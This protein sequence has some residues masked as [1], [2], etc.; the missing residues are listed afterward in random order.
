MLDLL[1]HLGGPPKIYMYNL[2]ICGSTVQLSGQVNEGLLCSRPPAQWGGKT[3]L[4]SST[5]LW[6]SHCPVGCRA[7]SVCE[8]CRIK[9]RGR[10]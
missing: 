3:A 2:D 7:V 8:V 5:S 9:E 1:C 4:R 10:D 6:E